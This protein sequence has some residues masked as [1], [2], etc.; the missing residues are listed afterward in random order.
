MNTPR[1]FLALLSAFFVLPFAL[2]AC[3]GGLPGN[4]VVKIG[5]DSIKTEEFDHWLQVA[6]Q[7]QQQSTGQTGKAVIPDA[8]D[9]KACIANKKKT[10]P[11]PAKGQP[12]PT[13]ATFK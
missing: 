5:G 10:A 12:E 13:D 4:A 1:R 9:Y 2:S 6:A 8:P 11:K 3:G 7:S